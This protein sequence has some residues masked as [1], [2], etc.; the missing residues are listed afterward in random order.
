M[1]HISPLT[2]RVFQ[3][4]PRSPAAHRMISRIVPAVLLGVFLAA[5]PVGATTTWKIDQSHSKILFTVTHMV[6]N[7]VGGWFADFE[8]SLTQQAPGNFDGSTVV[9]TIKTA[10]INTGSD[11]RDKHLRSADFFDAEKYPV[12]TFTSTRFKR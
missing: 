9:V 2:D 4:Q 10:S 8:G 12:T 5:A 6:I 11:G 3:I 1:S 7:E